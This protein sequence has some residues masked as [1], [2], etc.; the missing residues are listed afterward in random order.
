[1]IVPRARFA[2][3]LSEIKTGHSITRLLARK[4]RDKILFPAI[5]IVRRKSSGARRYSFG[6]ARVDCRKSDRSRFNR[7]HRET[8]N[9]KARAIGKIRGTVNRQIASKESARFLSREDV[10][11]SPPRPLQSFLSI[12]GA[13]C[14][15]KRNARARVSGTTAAGGRAEPNDSVR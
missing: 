12:R 11:P 13:S 14:R 10:P 3:G 7:S 1:M 8:A 2:L 15:H 6:P 5:E 9:K 4:R